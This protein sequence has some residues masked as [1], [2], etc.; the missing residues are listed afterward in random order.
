VRRLV[1]AVLLAIGV[2]AGDAQA[3]DR[4]SLVGGCYALKS[5]ATGKFVAKTAAGGYRA[6]AG[7]AGGA[8][9][10]RMQATDLGRYLLYGA[11]RDFVGVGKPLPLPVP[12]PTS[13]IPVP[14][15]PVATT[16]Q[17]GDRVR[18]AASPSETAD[19]RVSQAGGDFVI[20]LPAARGQVLT[21][22]GDGTVI[23]R[24]RA[25]AGTR[26]RWAFV[27]RG[28][29]LAYPE[30]P[31]DVSG[32][33]RTGSAPWSAVHGLIDGHMH[34][35][36]FE[37]LGGRVHCGRPWHPYGVPYAM[38]D[39]PD[40]YPNGAGAVGEN[41][42]SYGS[43]AHLHDPVGWP[44]FKDWPSYA[45]LTHEQS[46]YRWLER[47]WRAG[48]RVFVNLF[49]DNAVLC[50]LYPLKKNSCNEM[51][52]VR[53]QAR[54]IHELQDYIDAQSGGPGK[55]WFRIV[56][57]PAQ[58]RRV[59]NQGKLAVVEGIEVSKLF[60][61]GLN[62]ERAEC[63]A[64]QID[65]RLDEVYDMGV[66]DMELVNKF[67]NALAGVAGDSG[68]T[69]VVVNAGNRI[70]TGKFWQMTSCDGHNHVQDRTQY[71]FPAIERDSL[72]GNILRV[73]G[74]TGIAPVYPPAPHCNV[75]GLSSLGAHLVKRM[76]AKDMIIDP[77]HLS[78][79]ARQQLLD[80][81][82][83]ADYSGIIS[84]HS[85]STPDSIPRIYRLGGFVTPYAG[86]AQDFVDQWREQRVVR[87]KRF[88]QGVGWGADM[89]GF[90]AQGGP[91]N[92]PNP[93]TYPFK[94]WD[95]TVT[96][97]QQ[98]SGQR[99]YDINKDG[100]AHYG[101][102]P[103]WVEDVRHIAGQAIVDDLGRGA[104]A[105]LQMWERADGI[106]TGCRPAKAKATKRGLAGARLGASPA[107]LLKRAGQP[108]VRGARRWTYCVKGGQMAAALTRSGHVALVGS[109]A[110]GHKARGVRPG[111]KMKKGRA[112]RRRGRFVYV[113]RHR[114]VK[115]VA[116]TKARSRKVVRRQLKTAGLF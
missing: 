19:W 55:G 37:F 25:A 10:L 107:S 54:R 29:C 59:I 36:A 112:V 91:R 67:D 11:E 28:G 84:S 34:M 4:Y 23:M 64:Q 80:I 88:Y 20:D 81:V 45:S 63:T 8:E 83:A 74:P 26:G 21:V 78:V 110:R 92:G 60:D 68:T 116:V 44:T 106:K 15:L 85:W 47:S 50:E 14:D 24:D 73:F 48:Q 99:V 69:G 62:N 22:A 97:G 86:A 3:Q 109:T 27:P 111:A 108:K 71:T 38:V 32:P 103:D 35:M 5:A 1:V 43:A 100:V 75:R 6:T 89:N 31:L 95:G 2:C 56:T 105:Y 30:I 79:R 51:D 52:G 49:V 46:Y 93:V 13:P 12:S 114:R 96:V 102:Y 53:L 70:E 76:I 98:H 115:A 58:A 66:R 72:A 104:E 33:V 77:D 41:V 7:G 65:Q 16:T 87:D 82:E 90:G 9:P 40:H 101:L 39:C 17:T 42:L 61:C 18:S 94:N 57:S 113:V